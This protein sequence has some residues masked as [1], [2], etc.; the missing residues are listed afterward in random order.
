MKY[1]NPIP[2]ERAEHLVIYRNEREF[3]SWPFNA[4]MW[5]IGRD[6]V[7]V[8]F[9]NI[10]C[11]YSIP[12][13]KNHNRVETFGRIAAVRTRDGGK[14]WSEPITIA[15]NVELCERLKYGKAESYAEP[16]DFTNPQTLLS[17]WSTPNSFE[18]TAKAWIKISADGGNTWGP[19]VLLPPCNIPRFQGRP[20]YIVRP[21]GVILLFL[22]ARPLHNHYDRPVV[23]ASFDSG[24]NWALISFMPGSSEYR[25]ICPSPVLLDDGAILAAVRCKP[26]MEG[27]WN[28]L[29]AS[30][31]GGRT[32]HF[33]S[34][35]N[36]HG[37]TVHLTLLQD[38]RLYCVYGYRRPPFGIR[39]RISDDR[40]RTWGPELILRDDGGSNDLGYPRAVELDKGRMLNAYYFNERTDAI[41]ANGGVRYIGGTLLDVSE[42]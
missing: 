3:S 18:D 29:Y 2:V 14:S 1:E 42:F 38:G 7:L 25:V 24:C 15:N 37:D 30:E 16:F 26:S 12:L 27:A 20:S 23:Y 19:A 8:G 21:D 40:G 17:C 5:K 22:T 28:E 33:V 34:R 6:H 9:M 36:D 31:D 4:G 13:N 10:G 41:E 39:A 35:I 11:D 32:W